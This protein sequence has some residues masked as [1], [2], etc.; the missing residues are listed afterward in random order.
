M[1]SA[2]S[3]LVRFGERARDRLLDEHV[4]AGRERRQRIRH[5]TVVRRT[6][7]RGERT[8]VGERFGVAAVRGDAAELARERAG[9]RHVAARE[10]HGH[11]DPARGGRVAPRDPPASH[12]DEG[13]A[14]HDRT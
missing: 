11:P 10:D 6:D 1:R 5:V 8:R 13:V 4:A 2:A 9:P 3:N 12:H 14:S 7:D